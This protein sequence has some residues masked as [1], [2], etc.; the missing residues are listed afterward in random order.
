[1]G[2]IR[3]KICAKAGCNDYALPNSAYCQ[4]HQKET[5]RN[6]TSKFNS[7]Y[8]TAWWLKARKQFLISHIWCE[9]CL[10]KGKHT[11]S[12]VVHHSCGFHDWQ[13]FTDESKWTAVCS[14]CHSLI[15]SK[16]TNEDLYNLNKDKW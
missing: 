14:S 5:N 4:A 11:L 7:Y 1:M 12:N 16:V 13:T 3:K 9:E 10:K 15:H 8:K 2:Y 6:S